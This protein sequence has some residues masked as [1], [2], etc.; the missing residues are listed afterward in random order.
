LEFRLQAVGGRPSRIFLANSTPTRI[1]PGKF[2]MKKPIFRDALVLV[3]LL[4]FLNS[5]PALAQMPDAAGGVN[6]ALIRLFGDHLGF[7]ARADVQVFNSNRVMWLQMPSAFAADETKFRVDVDLKLVRSST[8]KPATIAT[9][10]Q[11]GMDRV[12]SVIRPDKKAIYIIYPGTQSYANMPISNEDAQLT[13]QRVEKKALGRE[14]IDGHACVKNLSTVK[15]PKGVVLLQATTWNAAD[16]KEF[17]VKI[18]TRENGNTTVMHFQQ[19]TMG[20]P[21]PKL[22]EPPAG[23][24]QYSNPQDLLM[25]AYKR[26]S[27]GAKK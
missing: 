17:P 16:L 19:V 18:E 2:D 23:Y 24:K 8:I 21:D 25:A 10:K 13:S 14:T 15:S 22:F 5:L 4:V 6:S 3:L 20:R 27:G 12:T 26:T 1:V 11:L 9:Y 7:T